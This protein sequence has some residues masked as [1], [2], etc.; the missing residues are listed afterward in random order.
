MKRI[1][2]I[3]LSLLACTIFS[4]CENDDTDMSEIIEVYQIKPALIEID[5][6]ALAED[7][8]VVPTD[9]T[10][11]TYGDYVENTNFDDKVITITWAGDSATVSGTVN[12]VSVATNGGHV[13]VTST[14]KRV[15]YILQGSSSN[16]SIKFY[17]EKKFRITLNG[18]A[19]TNPTGAAINNQCSK[20]FYVVL[21]AGTHNSLRDGS[22]YVD[23]DGEDQKG[24]LFSEG[25]I[26]FSGSGSLNV[27]A[28][29]RA[30]ISTDDYIVVRPGCRIYANSTAGNGIRGK[31][32]IFI[33][34][35]VVNVEV[36][37]DGAKGLR[38]KS[39]LTIAGGRTTVIAT[40]NSLITTDEETLLPDTTASAA[41][42]SDSLM[43]V[44]GGTLNLMATGDAGKGIRLKQ[45]YIQSGG[46]VQSVA[47]GT[48][49]Q[50][51]AK[52]AKIDGDFTVT[53][54][55]FYSYSSKSRPLDVAGTIAIATGYTTYTSN[56][57]VVTIDY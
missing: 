20:S 23:I 3:A 33:N 24:T 53:G 22:T 40:G 39:L 43:L 30:A 16:G 27:Y 52:G 18:L 14:A 51:K 46:K 28:T 32:G 35:G 4:A 8:D 15:Q 25:Q 21:N 2:Y 6:T 56:R 31:D 48:L 36:S 49:L 26:L 55:Y 5:S 19:L 41:V 44:T 10:D 9:E 37:A 17:S 34:G 47:T 13:T 29:G 12:K 42:K 54:G 11:E 50:G 7:A 38:S 57:K 1:L 45:S